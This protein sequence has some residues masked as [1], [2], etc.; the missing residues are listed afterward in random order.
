VTIGPRCALGQVRDQRRS[1]MSTRSSIARLIL[2][3][4]PTML[5]GLA[6]GFG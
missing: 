1:R 2:K 3:G 5:S 4:R 6:Y